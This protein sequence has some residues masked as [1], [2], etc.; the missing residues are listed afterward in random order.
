MPSRRRIA[1]HYSAYAQMQALDIRA[2]FSQIAAI[3][4]RFPGV[5]RMSA[6]IRPISKRK[7]FQRLRSPVA[8]HR[9]MHALESS[10]VITGGL[11]QRL[12]AALNL[13]SVSAHRSLCSLNILLIGHGVPNLDR[14][15]CTLKYLR[16]FYP[17]LSCYSNPPAR[18]P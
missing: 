16:G 9:E 14:K 3:D 18:P 8:I 15:L 13:P 4:H 12:R 17:F 11:I 1:R 2:Q 10:A 5:E 6:P 7:R